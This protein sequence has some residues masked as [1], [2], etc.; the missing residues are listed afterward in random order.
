[1]NTTS[2]ALVSGDNSLFR[3]CTNRNIF[4]GQIPDDKERIKTIIQHSLNEWI[5]SA[6]QSQLCEA[7]NQA[8]ILYPKPESTISTQVAAQFSRDPPQAGGTLEDE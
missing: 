8:I 7:K 6:R 5:R 1:V 4:L 2:E 3:K